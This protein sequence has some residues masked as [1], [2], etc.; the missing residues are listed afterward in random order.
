MAERVTALVLAAGLSSR[1][2]QFKP[3]LPLG[4]VTALERII[5]TFREAGVSDVRV[6]VGHRHEV[7]EPLVEKLGGRP[8]LNRNYQEGMFSSVIAGIGSLA[9]EV[10]AFF[11]QP[12]DVPL[13]RPS[14]I[15]SLLQ[16]HH[17]THNDLIYPSFLGRRG[18]PPLIAGRH[19]QAIA[20][21]RGD[22]GLQAILARWEESAQN[23]SVADELVL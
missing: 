2:Q 5:R 6:V 15:R 12:V 20:G 18:H 19:A 13:V 3:L 14:T 22:G 7:L 16:V 17:Q 21:W 9:P 8:V 4:G 1:M 10:D 11:V 23:V